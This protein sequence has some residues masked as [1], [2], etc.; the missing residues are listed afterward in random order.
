MTEEVERDRIINQLVDKIWKDFDTDNSGMLDK[1]ETRRF[2]MVILKDLPP[3]NNYE[4]EKF[5][6]TYLAIDKNGDGFI[7]K[8]EMN[9][10]IKSLVH[11]E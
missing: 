7:E 2:L 10:F 8:F 1:P 9:L 11:S 6:Q 5:E 3:P 4:E